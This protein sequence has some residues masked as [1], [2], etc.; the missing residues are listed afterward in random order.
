MSQFLENLNDK[1]Q[2]AVRC[3]EGPLLVL[4]GAGSGKTRVL[5]HRIGYML[6]KGVS[7][8]QILAITFTNKAAKEMKERLTA[9]IGED[10]EDMWV[11]T[12]H[13]SCVRILRRD[14]ESLNLGYGRNF[15]IFDTSDQQTVIK[16]AIKA[17]GLNDKNFPPR[18]VLSQISSAKNRMQSPEEFAAENAADYYKSRIAE[19]YKR[20]QQALKDS[21]GL[22]FDD[23]LMLTVMLFEKCPEVLSYYRRKFQYILVDEYQDT[24]P[25]QYRLVRLL[26]AEHQNLCVVGDDDQS[27][28]KFRGADIRNILD[29]EKD[30]PNTTVV[31]LEQN[32][33]STGNILEAANAVIAHNTGRK[34]KRLWT[35]EG[36][37]E[38]VRVIEANDERGEARAIA[39]VIRQLRGLE[40]R[41]FSDFTILYRMNA[42]SRVIEETFLHEAI[43]YRVYGGLRFYDRKEIKDMLAYLRLLQNPHDNI[44]LKRIINEPKRNIGA[45]TISQLESVSEQ[46][47]RSLFDVMSH[48][49]EYPELSKLSGKLRPFVT[50]IESLRGKAASLGLTELAKAVMDETGYMSM[51]M[52][53]D[54]V[55]NRTRIE[56]LKELLTVTEE[57]EKAEEGATLESF[58]EGVSLNADI[59]N[60]D[61]AADA[62]NMMTLHSAKGLEFPVV[63]LVGMEENIFPS[64]RSSAE[65]EEMEEERRLCYVGVTRARER[66]VLTHTFSRHMF[67][68]T[69]YNPCSRFLK[70]MP[71]EL[72]EGLSEKTQRTATHTQSTPRPSLL[73]TQASRYTNPDSVAH[74]SNKS[75]VDISSYKVGQTVSHVRFGTGLILSISPM[76]SDAKLEI[77]FEKVGTKQ[78]MASYA[79]LKILA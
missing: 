61:D 26:A 50:L 13:A 44:S 54:V 73:T 49:E 55:E 18:A 58:L 51:L 21:N 43:P 15:V 66:L 2:E 20:Y 45:T 48:A 3:T 29:F 14:I 70:E 7:P 56:N 40:R 33:R 59:D 62:V 77:A 28:Y 12:F 71:K 72:L 6:E 57:A 65:E 19:I 53:N 39:E 5:T 46:A 22:D 35:A 8:W 68:Q 76:G 67:G 60:F 41:N 36:K 31:K 42:Q 27:I 11:S 25:V 16:E 1:Q 32:Y 69:M 78:L 30:F 79:K 37:G 23:I 9:M 38:K 10:V 75:G 4:A 74:I 64:S 63:F 52:A 47:G 24:N 17:M 34:E